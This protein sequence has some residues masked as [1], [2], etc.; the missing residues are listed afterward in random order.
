M[1]TVSLILVL[2]VFSCLSV[3][4]SGG[5]SGSKMAG[6][7]IASARSSIT[8]LINRAWDALA[9]QD[10]ERFK[11][12]TLAGFQLYTAHGNKMDAERLF[13]IHR[14]SMRDFHLEH[15][16]LEINIH[17]GVAWATYDAEMSGLRQ[18]EYW[19]EDF[20]FTT[21]FIHKDDGWKVAHMQESMV[22]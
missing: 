16:N 14:Q 19:S 7:D 18:G 6:N 9:A 13:E 12:C 4:C 21:I 11:Q 5:R 17:D 1:R 20:I 15:T 22:Q 8:D 3:S 2:I 10:L